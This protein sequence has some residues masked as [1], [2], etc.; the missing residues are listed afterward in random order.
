MNNS[1]VIG[2][3][4]HLGFLGDIFAAPSW[5]PAAN[6]FSIGDALIVAGIALL[7]A[8]TMRGPRPVVESR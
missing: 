5:M 4:T 8:V 7:L 1:A 2:A 3:G 6:V